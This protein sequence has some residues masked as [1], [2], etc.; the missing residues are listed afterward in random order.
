MNVQLV[1]LEIVIFLIV[2]N[3]RTVEAFFS[4]IFERFKWE[5]KWLM[6]IAWVTGAAIVFLAETNLFAGYIPNELVGRVLTAI[7][8]GGG[9]NLLHML[10]GAI[11]RAA[12]N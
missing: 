2:V 1:P 10:F 8:A 9:S 4:P 12:R 7:V 6:Y 5:T 3:E 11:D